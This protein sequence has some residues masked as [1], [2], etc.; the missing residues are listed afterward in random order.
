MSD[1]FRGSNGN[2][3]VDRGGFRYCIYR[4]TEDM[5]NVARNGEDIA[6]AGS[7]TGAKMWI[8]SNAEGETP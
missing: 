3:F 2:L 1:Y 7:E 8:E 6:T 4:V 5:Y